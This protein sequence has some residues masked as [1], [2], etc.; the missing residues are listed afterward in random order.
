M[1]S[2]DDGSNEFLQTSKKNFNIS[3]LI[4]IQPPKYAKK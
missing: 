1:N 3:R 4:P 2:M